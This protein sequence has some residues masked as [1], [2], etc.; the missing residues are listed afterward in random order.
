MIMIQKSDLK[1]IS[2]AEFGE[3]LSR[4]EEQ[5]K[6]S[7]IKF[8][9][10]IP[11]L[12]SGAFTGMHLASKLKVKNILPAQYKYEFLPEETITKKFEFPKLNYEL[13][14]NPNVLI[15]DSNTVFGAIAAKVI[16][17]IKQK[18]PSSKI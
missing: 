3:I 8:D 18:Y 10:I 16:Q 14:Q 6:D 4:L 15:C 9:L 17:G 11:I 1:P 13:A 2:Y 5:V 7:G 12:R